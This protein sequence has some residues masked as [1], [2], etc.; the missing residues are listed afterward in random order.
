[1]AY[2]SSPARGRIRAAAAGLHHS[3]S[4]TRSELHLQPTLSSFWQHWILNPLSKARDQTCI[5]LDTSWILNLLSHKGNSKPLPFLTFQ[6]TP[7]SERIFTV[8]PPLPT[9]A[10]LFIHSYKAFQRQNIMFLSH[11]MKVQAFR[12]NQLGSVP[13]VHTPTLTRF[14]PK[15]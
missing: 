10:S 11:S 2:G 8:T 13:R 4:N 1:M 3:H 14:H 15:M 12:V 6:A 9:S 5:L 7:S